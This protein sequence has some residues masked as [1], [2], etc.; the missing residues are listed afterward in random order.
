ML[1]DRGRGGTIVRV[2][3]WAERRQVAF[4]AGAKRILLPKSSVTDIPCVPGGLFAKFQT[5]FYS[6]P[7]DA[8]FKALGVE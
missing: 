1:D 6:D 3:N 4:E 7:V 2:R 8:V 5:R